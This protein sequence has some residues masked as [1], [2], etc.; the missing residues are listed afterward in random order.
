MLRSSVSLI[1]EDL[2]S[3]SN[4][5]LS[6]SI[7]FVSCSCYT[8]AEFTANCQSTR[9]STELPTLPCLLVGS[10]SAFTREK[11]SVYLCLP[12]NVKTQIEIY[13]SKTGRKTCLLLQKV[14]FFYVTNGQKCVIS[15]PYVVQTRPRRVCFSSRSLLFPWI[16]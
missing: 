8:K 5:S 14:H 16:I 10:P 7:F 6:S 13:C 15:F 11:V 9:G 12:Q 3:L 1:H 4:R 2:F